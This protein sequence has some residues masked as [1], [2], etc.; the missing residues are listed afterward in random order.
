MMAKGVA[1]RRTQ[2]DGIPT[3]H[4]RRRYGSRYGIASGYRSG[5]GSRSGH[6][7]PAVMVMMV[8][9]FGL[10]PAVVA[11]ATVHVAI[12]GHGEVHL[13]H[14]RPFCF[15]GFPPATVG[16]F[17]IVEQSLESF[18]GSRGGRHVLMT[19]DNTDGYDYYYRPIETAAITTG[20]FTAVD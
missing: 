18:Q 5:G 11:A 1:T 13:F 9:M 6:H 12:G 10:A 14:G 7:A 8:Q 15:G 20:H 2:H 16:E 4:A 3:T 17:N 19:H